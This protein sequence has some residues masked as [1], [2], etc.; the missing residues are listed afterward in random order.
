MQSFYLCFSNYKSGHVRICILFVFD[1]FKA[2]TIFS[3]EVYACNV[4]FY[5][6][7]FVWFKELLKKVA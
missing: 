4:I 2:V 7:Q 6:Y 3:N 5:S 1:K